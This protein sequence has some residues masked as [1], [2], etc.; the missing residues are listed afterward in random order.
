MLTQILNI[1]PR[2]DSCIETPA[3]SQREITHTTS[4]G[5]IGNNRRFIGAKEVVCSSGFPLARRIVTIMGLLVLSECSLDDDLI[6][7][8]YFCMIHKIAI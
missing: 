1:I 8:S 7:D 5:V 6:I 3:C 2:R 4:T